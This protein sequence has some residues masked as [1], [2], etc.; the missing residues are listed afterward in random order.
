MFSLP[1]IMERV[2]GINNSFP[3]GMF[4]SVNVLS[5]LDSRPFEHEFFNLIA[6]A[7]PSLRILVNNI[8]Q[9]RKQQHWQSA[10][11]NNND[12]NS[13]ITVYPHLNTLYLSNV[14]VHYVEQFLD[15]NSTHLPSLTQ[16]QMKYE[17]LTTVT[18]NFTNNKTRLNC[19]N[20]ENICFCEPVVFQ[21]DFYLYFPS[22]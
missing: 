1:F 5:M 4:P 22:L 11:D 9:V 14:H 15:E 12:Q 13:S 20:L 8:P 2:S 3:G 7:F 17:Q 18:N 21:K 6:R 10:D 19:A 16:L